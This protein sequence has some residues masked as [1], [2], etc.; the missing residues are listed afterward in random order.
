LSQAVQGQTERDDALL[1]LVDSMADLYSFVDDV[2][3]LENKIKSLERVIIRIS[4]QMTECGIF[5]K[6]FCAAGRLVRQPFSNTSQTIS[7]LSQALKQLGGE[8]QLGVTSHTAFVSAQI[9]RDVE[10]LGA[11]TSILSQTEA[12]KTLSPAAM[13]AG[14]RDTC[15]PG[16]RADILENLINSLI[17]PSG[18]NIIWFRGP[19]GSGKSTILTSVAQYFSELGRRGSF[20]FWD[21]NDPVNSDPVRVIRTLAFQ[22]GRFKPEIRAKLAAQIENSPDITTSPLDTQFKHLLEQPLA[23]L[24]KECD[25]A[26]IV[27]VLDALDECGTAGTRRNLLRTFSEGLARLP[28]MF[29]LLVASRDEPDIRAALSHLDVDVRD[30]PIGDKSTLSDIKLLFQQQLASNADAFKTYS[31]PPN[32]LTEP[33]IDKLVTLSGGLFIWASTTIRFIQSGFPEERLETVLSGSVHDPS[34]DGLNELYRVALT[35]PFKSYNES[36]FKVVHSIVGAIVVAREQLMDEQLRQL[37]ELGIGK[38]QAVLSQ[39]QPLLR[40][41]YGGPIQVLHT[42]F[43]DFLCNPNRCQD[44]RWYI[45]PSVHHLDLAS[46]CLRIMQRDLKFNICGIETSYCRNKEIKGL[47]ERVNRAVTPVLMYA[48]QYWVDHLEFGSGPEP[49]SPPLTNEIMDFFLHRFLH[50][51]EV[52]SVMDR[53]SMLSV[54]LR[55]LVSWASVSRFSHARW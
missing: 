27:I 46:R 25:L 5:I 12:L 19:A 42:S 49:A 43:T 55:R 20:L 54:I 18:H 36:E 40:G 15:L 29:R 17:D 28:S 22:L 21:R 26:P 33:V 2:D 11:M 53:I 10:K 31:L 13:D 8:L 14:N 44:P 6:Q 4:V 35:H 38:V 45:N 51:I 37:L 3:E 39:F 23:E 7:N 48:S 1:S 41:D 47:Q 9:S 24:A 34:D 52:F 16:T 32:W 50:W 30:A